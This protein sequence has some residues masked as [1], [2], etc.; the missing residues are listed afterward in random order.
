MHTHAHVDSQFG[1]L[2]WATAKPE[3]KTKNASGVARSDI[4]CLA[5]LRVVGLKG[6][7]KWCSKVIDRWTGPLKPLLV[8]HNSDIL[9]RR[10]KFTT[11]RAVQT[12][13]LKRHFPGTL[14]GTFLLFGR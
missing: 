2:I 6:T 11:P 9:D 1:E 10:A 7:G 13:T 3:K 12:R 5:A 8:G 4:L 14:A